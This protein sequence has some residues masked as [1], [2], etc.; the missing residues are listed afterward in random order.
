MELFQ[1]HRRHSAGDQGEVAI[2]H[3]QELQLVPINTAIRLDLLPSPRKDEGGEK[4]HQ[5]KR[6]KGKEILTGEVPKE[7]LIR[8]AFL[9]QPATFDSEPYN[10]S[11]KACTSP[12]E[13][14][15][16]PINL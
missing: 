12:I 16:P 2:D 6:A 10:R 9:S 5:R 7:C 4:E 11:A 3:I 15:K 8:A 14:E 1:L 13:I